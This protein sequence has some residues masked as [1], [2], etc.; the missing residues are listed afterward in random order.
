MGKSLEI[1]V[2]TRVLVPLGHGGRV[3][4]RIKSK[5]RALARG[6][7]AASSPWQC[8]LDAQGLKAS[9]S[10]VDR[11]LWCGDEPRVLGNRS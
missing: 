6:L 3:G 5:E 9:T 11:A 4:M 10:G 7:G 8:W 1:L 2:Q